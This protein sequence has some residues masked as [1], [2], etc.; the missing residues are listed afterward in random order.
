MIKL[1]NEKTETS[2]AGA[3]I[4]NGHIRAYKHV[5]LDGLID[6]VKE[7]RDNYDPKEAKNFHHIA[8]LDADILE[9]IRLINGFPNTPEGQK[10]TVKEAVR[11]VKSGELAAFAIHGA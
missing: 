9:N 11:M 6:H 5:N 10:E 7:L 1:I 4:E 8:R 2:E 3:I